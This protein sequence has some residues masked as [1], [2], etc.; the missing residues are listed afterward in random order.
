[1][2][3][4][5]LRKI[6]CRWPQLAGQPL[7]LNLGANQRTGPA[8][9]AKKCFIAAAAVGNITTTVN[10]SRQAGLMSSILILDVYV[11]VSLLFVYCFELQNFR[12]HK[13]CQKRRINKT[14]T[15]SLVCGNYILI[16]RDWYRQIGRQWQVD[17][18]WY[19][20]VRIYRQVGVLIQEG[21]YVDRGR[22]VDIGWYML[23]G[24]QR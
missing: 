20:L 9:S 2:V 10:K 19:M 13:F 6:D 21:R 11:T 16:F 8:Y 1:M 5:H 24:C 22:Q 15:G 12:H 7:V 23:V 14:D 4:R 17:M 18:V 3:H